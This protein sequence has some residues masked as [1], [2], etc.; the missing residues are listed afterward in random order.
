MV[1]GH[2]GNLVTLNTE[3][4]RSAL[5]L[6][7]EQRC[8]GMSD[9]LLPKKGYL[10][11]SAMFCLALELLTTGKS[12]IP[13]ASQIQPAEPYHLT[14]SAANG[15]QTGPVCLC[16]TRQTGCVCCKGSVVPAWGVLWV[17]HRAGPGQMLPAVL[18]AALGC[19]LPL[20]SGHCPQHCAKPAPHIGLVCRSYL[21]QRPTQHHSFGS[22]VRRLST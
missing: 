22:C 11:I 6:E 4:S 19:V 16:G 10:F 13:H 18:V 14:P 7:R 15:S 20:C 9:K 12:K 3:L 8:V 1:L 2:R 21:V 17:A 5:S